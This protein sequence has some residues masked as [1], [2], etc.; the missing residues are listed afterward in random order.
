MST[1]PIIMCACGA[2]ALF[3]LYAGKLARVSRLPSLVGYLVLGMVIGV[4]GLNILDGAGLEKTA[5]LTKFCLGFV[6]F[7]IGSE[8]NLAWLKRQGVGVVAVILAESLGAF[9]VV[10]AGV[11]MLT[12]DLPM[13]IMFAAVAPASAPAGTVSVIR[14]CRARGPLTR[15]LYAVVGF[16]DALAIVIYAVAAAVAQGV[17]GAEAEGG[18]EQPAVL[19]CSA[20]KEIGVSIVIG[21]VCGVLF[22]ALAP[23]L[24]NSAEVLVLLFGVTGI[25]VGLAELFHGSLILANM[26]VGIIPANVRSKGT[27]R[28][29]AEPVEGVMP[30][31]FVLFF[32]LAG[33][34]L[35]IAMLPEIGLLGVVYILCRS[36]GLVG[37]SRLGA[38]LG[39]MDETIKKYVGLGI[40]S[41]AGVAIGLALVAKE[42]FD[43]LGTPEA[44]R[45]GSHLIITITATSIVFELIG[46]ILTKIALARAGE[47]GRDEG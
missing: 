42:Q 44:I 22:N 47:I 5:F 9:L 1:Q 6:A 40:L 17:L 13:A 23:R 18:G 12:G 29:I 27:M 45:I 20:L 35:D 7:A 8:L 33:A 21:A 37:G 46:P 38:A 15:V 24:T 30:L 11:Y 32:G 25:A 26:I 28:R 2:I 31:V 3:G 14:E 4:S 43:A 39:R 19:L 16:D 41:Q 10:F 34:H 36:T